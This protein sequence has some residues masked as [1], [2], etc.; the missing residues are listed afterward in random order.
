MTTT[1]AMVRG[2]FKR[3]ILWVGFVLVAIPLGVL[4]SLQYGWLVSLQRTSAIAEK[5]TLDNYLEAVSNDVE[6]FYYKQAWRALNIPEDLLLYKPLDK[7]KYHFKKKSVKGAK[8]L[9]AVKYTA[10]EWAKLAIYDPRT[11]SLD[12]EPPTSVQ[13]AIHVSLAPW[14]TLAHSGASLQSHDL[15]VD[16]RDPDN[17]IILKPISQDES[18]IIGVAGMIVDNDFFKEKILPAAI[19]NAIPHFFDRGAKHLMIT[20]RDDRDHVVYGKAPEDAETVDEAAHRIAF[21]FSDWELAL[22]RKH[23]TTEQL[24]QS[25]FLINMTLSALLTFAL[26]GG[27]VM[28]LRT[29]SRE[30]KLSTMK[31]DFVSNV[32]HELRTPLASIRVFGEFLRLGRVRDE[33]KTREYGEYIETQS[34]R[35]T[36]LINNILDFSKIESGAKTYKFEPTDVQDV[37]TETLRTLEVSVRQKG[38]QLAFE[39]PGPRIPEL[40][41]DPDAIA[42]ALANLLDNAIKYSDGSTDIAVSLKR[43]DDEVVIGVRDHG[44]GISRDEQAKIFERFHRVS[45]GLV[46]DVKGSGLGLSIVNHIVEAHG[47]KVTV[48]SELGQGSTFAIHLPLELEVV[49]RR[50]EAVAEPS[51]D[52]S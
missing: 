18:K 23:D 11:E 15:T 45:T 4:L 13:R 5:A 8:Y 35:L 44:V 22:H 32:S 2:F 1:K 30:V 36:Q 50:P 47:G 46:H 24:A 37:V 12:T 41:I 51:P 14:K 29:A 25:N 42:Q 17:R 3:H 52:Y 21:V 39:A 38:F 16:E 26:L 48:E 33:E 27:I 31:S 43:T 10:D 34:R 20:V 9:F 49:S 19:K 28:A 7:V 6:H 40:N